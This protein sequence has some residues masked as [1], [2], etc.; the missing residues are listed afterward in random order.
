MY[1]WRAATART[2]LLARR[3]VAV[4]RRGLSGANTER[5]NYLMAAALAAF[6]G[7]VYYSAMTRMRQTDDLAE[8][9]RAPA[10]QRSTRGLPRRASRRDTPRARAGPRAD[11]VA[12]SRAK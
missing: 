10:R 1:L 6:T 11:T 7:S 9:E 3:P 12:G 2:A 8:L 5:N 4:Q